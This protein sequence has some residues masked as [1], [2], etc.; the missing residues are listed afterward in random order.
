[1]LVYVGTPCA[2]QSHMHV[3]TSWHN[4][5]I[6]TSGHA[7]SCNVHMIGFQRSSARSVCNSVKHETTGVVLGRI[8]EELLSARAGWGL[9]SS[10][11]ALGGFK[12][13]PLPTHAHSAECGQK[14][15]RKKIK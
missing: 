13:V 12:R 11:V 15:E 2:C 10:R 3:H 1:M 4:H 8:L 6:I 9:E 5:H 7:A 14:K